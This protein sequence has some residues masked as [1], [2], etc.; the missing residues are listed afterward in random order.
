MDTSVFEVPES[1]RSNFI[2]VDAP[3]EEAKKPDGQKKVEKT[4]VVAAHVID[5]VEGEVFKSLE[6]ATSKFEKL[7][8]GKWAACLFDPAFE[9][10]KKY[11]GIGE[12]GWNILK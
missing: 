8:G 2:K 3:V 11:G 4:W 7:N 9:M 1:E 12:D 5:H 10:L 6:D